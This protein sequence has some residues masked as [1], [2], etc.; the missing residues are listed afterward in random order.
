MVITKS[1]DSYK[2][3]TVYKEFCAR[4]NA[5]LLSKVEIFIETITPLLNIINAGPFKDYTLHNNQH[6]KKDALL[7]FGRKNK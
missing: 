4:G 1:P 6:S 2:E 5:L 3:T 7:F